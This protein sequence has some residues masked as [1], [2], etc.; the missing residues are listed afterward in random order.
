MG[1]IYRMPVGFGPSWGPRQGPDGRRFNGELARTTVFT[2]SYIT[3]R[4]KLAALLPPNT[5]PA[6]EPL[7]TIRMLYNKDFA[8]LAGRAYHYLEVLFRAVYQGERD[9]VEGDFVAVMWEGMADAAIVG[10]EEVG[11]PKLVCDVP[12][13]VIKDG[14]TFATASWCGFTFYEGSFDHA[15]T[16]WPAE[17][18]ATTPVAPPGQGMSLRPRLNYK[19]I[20]NA[21]RMEEADVAYMAMMPAG[22]YE[23]RIL[24]K[25]SGPATTKWNL[26]RWEDL[27]T[28]G[29]VSNALR[30]LPMLDD[31]GGT[32]V[33]VLRAANDLRD[34]MK[35][36]R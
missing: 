33:R 11:H 16:P 28:F 31:R 35:I 10:R 1:N 34:V 9:T 15:L 25:W 8:W 18:E 24:E 17:R 13:P 30:D 23:Q 27:P 21:E 20:P 19:Y 29:N 22:A 36:L 3:D 14:K 2:H 4:A 6:E 12:D 32:M 5:V 7:V 26:A